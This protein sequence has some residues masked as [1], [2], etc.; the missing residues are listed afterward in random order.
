MVYF[1]SCKKITDENLTPDFTFYISMFD[2][3]LEEFSSRFLDFDNMRPQLTLK[4]QLE[5]CDLQDGHFLHTRSETEM[6]FWNLLLRKVHKPKLRT[7]KP[8]SFLPWPQRSPDLSASDI[9]LWEII[10]QDV[11]KKRY[12]S[13]AVHNAF[14]IVTPQMLR[15]MRK[16]TGRH[17]SLQTPWR[18]TYGCFESAI[19]VAQT[20]NSSSE[21]EINSNT[22]TKMHV[23]DPI[24]GDSFGHIHCGRKTAHNRFQPYEQM[25]DRSS[26]TK[27]SDMDSPH[28][29]SCVLATV[30][31]S[32]QCYIDC[33][34]P[35]ILFSN[36]CEVDDDG[37]DGGG[38]EQEEE[39]EEEE[40]EEDDDDEVDEHFQIVAT[41]AH[42][43]PRNRDELWNQVIDTWEDLA[44]DQNLLHNLVTSMPD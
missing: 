31:K 21:V 11:R 15:E 33:E 39:E 43:R 40:E 24:P 7:G 23:C 29:L 32:R 41:Y 25:N 20:F 34:Q 3:L 37:N 19:G 38:E 17:S 1:P 27:G 9:T 30:G 18:G 10:K 16:R 42:R 13:K 36:K 14:T 22:E 2:I 35:G 28:C 5:L 6:E 4:V 12:V 8:F 26:N 44:E